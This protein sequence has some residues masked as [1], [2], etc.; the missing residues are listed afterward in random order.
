[1]AILAVLA[2]SSLTVAG[3]GGFVALRS[4]DAAGAVARDPSASRTM[5]G[6]YVVQDPVIRVTAPPTPTAAPTPT[7]TPAPITGD[8]FVA[9]AVG[10]NVALKGLTATGGEITPGGFLSAFWIRNLG[11]P[12]ARGAEGTVYVVM[13]SVRGGGV[14]PGNYLT[15]IR[16]GTSA[17]PVGAAIR[18]AGVE[19][20]VTGSRTVP[21]TDL[22]ADAEV[23]APTPGRLV[24]ITCLERPDGAPSVLNMVIEAA[25]T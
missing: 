13:H 16:H 17:L 8:R 1:M 6:K 15:D 10:L 25:R 20:R 9:P 24:V 4:A 21:R 7:P 11:V 22:A 12:V 23:W 19:Y 3:I 18:V 5:D 2:G 14:G